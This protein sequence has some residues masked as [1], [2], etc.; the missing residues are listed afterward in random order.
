MTDISNID[1][2]GM[3]MECRRCGVCCT[4]YQAIVNMTEIQEIADYLCI[5]I[6]DWMKKYSEP[7]WNSHKSQL[8]RHNDSGCVFLKREK[9]NT[10]CDI[11]PARPSCCSEWI[12]S[13]ENSECQEGLKRAAKMD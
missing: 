2:P 12:P 13:L 1:R 10:A 5:S 11:H 8:I 9:E 7:R 6:D 3:L 4:K